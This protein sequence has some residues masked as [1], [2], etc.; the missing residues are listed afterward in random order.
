M[1]ETPAALRWTIADLDLFLDHETKHYEIIDGELYVSKAPREEHQ[2][3]TVEIGYE[4]VGWNRRTGLGH[5]LVGPG[6]I[7][8]ESDAVI[9]DLVWMSRER[10]AVIV[11]QDGHLHGAPELIVE[12]LSPGDKNEVRDRDTKLRL[13]SRYGVLEYWIVDPRLETVAVYRRHEAQLALV[14]TLTHDDSITS[15]VLPGFSAAV[16]SFFPPR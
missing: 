12:V 2:E 10:R 4:L 9:P 1:A 16:A 14:A 8:S 5:V 13:Y 11:W 7:F 3:A 6:V 15:P